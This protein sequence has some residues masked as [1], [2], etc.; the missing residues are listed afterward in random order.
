MTEFVYLYLGIGGSGGAPLSLG[1]DPAGKTQGFIVMHSERICN[2]FIGMPT[3]TFT[4][5]PNT[6]FLTFAIILTSLAGICLRDENVRLRWGQL[7]NCMEGKPH[8]PFI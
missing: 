7:R 5:K 3:F 6:M 2:S 1:N 4:D 8:L